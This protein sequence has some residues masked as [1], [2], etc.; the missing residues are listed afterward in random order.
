[1]LISERATRRLLQDSLQL[2]VSSG[3][4]ESTL[5][6][7]EILLSELGLCNL[8]LRGASVALHYTSDSLL[9]VSHLYFWQLIK[10]L[11]KVD[12]TTLARG[13]RLLPSLGHLLLRLFLRL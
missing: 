9:V 11:N 12:I 5:G 3:R 6:E 2:L 7:V 1:M 4:P 8:W 10:L 13:N